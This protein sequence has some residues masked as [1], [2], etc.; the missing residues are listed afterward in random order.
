M[1]ETS[2]RPTGASSLTDE[3]RAQLAR[4][5][6]VLQ[7]APAMLRHL[8]TG[9]VG[10]LFADDVL[11]RVRG[12][13]A[14]L[15]D[16]LVQAV[17]REYA[18]GGALPSGISA[19]VIAGD[20]AAH[21]AI[22]SHLHAVALEWQLSERLEARFGLDPVVAPLVQ[23]L[24]SSWQDE[25]QALAAQLL[26]AQARWC[27]AQ[28]RMELPLAELPADVL[29]AA[30]LALRAQAG[31]ENAWAL[32]AEASLRGGFDEAAGRLALAARLVTSLGARATSSLSILDGG[33]AL[34]LSALS[35][36]A[37]ISR[38]AAVLTVQETQAVRLVLQ[39][40]RAGLRAERALEQAVVLHPDA[41][42]PVELNLLNDRQIGEIL[43]RRGCAD[44]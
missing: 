29:H 27:R 11:A 16:Q 31:G 17:S 28:R 38:E 7:S 25:A 20:L 40:R 21:S 23:S 42:L 18:R 12:M 4:G 13:I 8:V 15:A 26:A 5:E 22:L 2:S 43:A 34:F 44:E 14:H 1:I 32:A 30:L 33:V 19:R 39:L 36:C 10:A 9:E 35:H 37:A 24:V 3:V 41:A 6:A